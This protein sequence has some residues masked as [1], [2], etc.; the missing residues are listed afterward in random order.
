ML[1]HIAEVIG[2]DPQAFIEVELGSVLDILEILLRFEDAYGL[3]PL[4]DSKLDVDRMYGHAS[5]LV[6][7]IE[8]EQT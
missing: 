6:T 7:S 2:V 3:I 1:G 8:D 5:K 4:E